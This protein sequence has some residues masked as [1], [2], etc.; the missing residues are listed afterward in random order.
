MNPI[1]LTTQDVLQGKDYL[2]LAEKTAFV[3]HAAERCF[4]RMNVSLD[5]GAGG[6]DLPMAPM[7][8]ENTDRKGRYLMG[9]LARG[10]LG[11]AFQPAEKDPWLMSQDDYDRWA[12]GHVLNQLERMK[13]QRGEARD[14]VFDLL[15]DYRDAERR[16]NTEIRGM[17]TVMNEPVNRILATMQAQTTPEAFLE[18]KK[19]LDELAEELKAYRDKLDTRRQTAGGGEE[20]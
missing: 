10:Y 6:L 11:Q 16:L 5:N 4:D 7:Y 9:L 1:K 15:A 12:G 19:K 2:T 3:A 14:K 8:K 13:G 20:A 17:L 18:G